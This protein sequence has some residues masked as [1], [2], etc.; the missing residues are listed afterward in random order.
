MLVLHPHT[1]PTQDGEE[2]RVLRLLLE[3]LPVKTAVRLAAEI[4]GHARNALYEAALTIKR[5]NTSD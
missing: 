4:T 2:L 5:E 1:A 3:E